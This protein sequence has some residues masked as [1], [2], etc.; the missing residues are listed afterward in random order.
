MFHS[1][2]KGSHVSPYLIDTHCRGVDAFQ[3]LERTLDFGQI[4][5]PHCYPRLFRP[6]AFAPFTPVS[7]IDGCDI[8]FLAALAIGTFRPARQP[9][10]THVDH[11][12]QPN[13]S[14]TSCV[15]ARRPGSSD[16][17]LLRAG[18]QGNGVTAAV[19]PY[20]RTQTARSQRDLLT[21]A[22][23]PPQK[24]ASLRSYLTVGAYSN[25]LVRRQ[26]HH[27]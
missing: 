17:F 13:R 10:D 6:L 21:D 1:A 26:H 18:G 5:R 23:V 4:C 22:T 19:Y 12:L 9:L 25:P 8:C 24:T 14:A 16:L 20:L 3:T 11:H 27:P 15:E 7:S 2:H